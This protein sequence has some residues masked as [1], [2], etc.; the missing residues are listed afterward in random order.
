MQKR[1]RALAW[2]PT[3]G[4]LML[5]LILAGIFHF[6]GR[7]QDL[8]ACIPEF[9]ALSLLAGALY[10]A[11]VYLVEKSPLGP[12]ALIIILGGTLAFR[13]FVLPIAP[14][15]SGDVYRYQWEGRVHRRGINP[16]TVYPATPGLA[17]LQDPDHP[18]EGG[19]GTPT[20]YPPLSEFSFSWMETVQGYK[21]LYT[22]LDLASVVVLLILLAVRKQPLH[23]VLIYAWNPTVVVSFA[24]SGHHDSLAILTLLVS[25]LFI[26]GR[27]PVLSIAFLAL[28][29]LSKFFAAL[30]LPILVKR[31]RWAYAGLFAALVLLAYLPYAGAGSKLLDG[32]GQYAAGWEGNDSLFRLVQLAGNSKPQAYLVVG[33]LLLGLVVFVLRQRMEPLRAGLILTA[34]LVLLSPNAFPWY[35]TWTIPFLCFYPSVPWL[36]MTVTCVLGY[37]PVVAYAAGQ[38]YVD[39]PFILALEYAPV[40]AWLGYEAMR[41]SRNSGAQIR[42]GNHQFHD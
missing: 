15:I 22:G 2:L 9:I 25:M 5:A 18:L 38:P 27:R 19:S 24:M 33:T 16:Y 42:I 39:S 41:A 1:N 10:L 40:F 3:L 23:R 34:G 36:L 6:L 31:T 21:R 7:Q 35:F 37:A 26:I 13:L 11:G 32:L 28:S 30:L 4:L 29:F 12:A 20:L 17:D 8:A 14:A